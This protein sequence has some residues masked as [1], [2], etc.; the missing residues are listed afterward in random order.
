MSYCRIL[1]IDD[2]QDFTQVFKLTLEEL[3][4]YEVRVENSSPH[5]L[6]TVLEYHPD[7][8]FLDIIMPEVEGPDVLYALRNNTA[9]RNIPIIILTATITKDEVLAQ[10]GIIGG[11]IFAAKPITV[12]EV[13]DCIEKNKATS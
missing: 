5:A 9:T 3:A 13:I 8:I 1:I 4:P 7:I 6:T 12:P 2:D 10:D 11:H